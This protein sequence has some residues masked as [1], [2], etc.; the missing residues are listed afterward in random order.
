MLMY[1]VVPTKGYL[2]RAIPSRE[3]RIPALYFFSLFMYDIH[4]FCFFIFSVCS[5]KN[6]QIPHHMWR[7]KLN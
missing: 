2:H 3:E 4:T 5:Q 7:Q 1:K 6:H